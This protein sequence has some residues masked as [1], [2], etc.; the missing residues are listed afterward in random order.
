M[1]AEDEAISA[2]F[3]I[4]STVATS[5]LDVIKYILQAL[6]AKRANGEP[7]A[8]VKVGSAVGR[9]IGKVGSAAAGAIY[10]RTTRDWDGHGRHGE[11]SW[12]RAL[13]WDDQQTFTVDQTLTDPENIAA[14][15]REWQKARG[16]DD[17][18]LADELVNDGVVADEKTAD[19]L[20]DEVEHYRAT[21]RTVPT[22]QASWTGS[23]ASS[24]AAS[25]PRRSSSARR[26]RA[27]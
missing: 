27:R 20:I 12:R 18:E 7:G 3:R 16:V 25:P 24:G 1:A 21:R 11:V 6:L 14:L 19:D 2:V 10:D 22:R 5:T 13:G 26:S 15:T 8:L 4:G 23:R 17:D 9:G